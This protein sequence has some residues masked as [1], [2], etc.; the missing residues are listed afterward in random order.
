MKV[1]FDLD[2]GPQKGYWQIKDKK[3]NV[4]YFKP[5]KVNLIMICFFFQSSL[6]I[7]TV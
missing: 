5:K 1:R 7:E 4:H 6:T 3:G 2:D